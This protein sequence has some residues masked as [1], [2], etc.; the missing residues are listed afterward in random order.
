MILIER[1]HAGEYRSQMTPELSKAEYIRQ[2][3]IHALGCFGFLINRGSK[4]NG[5]EF[6]K[7]IEDYSSHERAVLVAESL[8]LMDENEPMLVVHTSSGVEFIGFQPEFD[9][10]VS[11]SA[12]RSQIQACAPI[13]E[14]T[15]MSV[16]KSRLAA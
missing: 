13:N 12:Q 3:L 6:A 14:L 8:R 4:I 2:M 16:F 11:P 7:L 5:Q 1:T 9:E 15:S 10:G